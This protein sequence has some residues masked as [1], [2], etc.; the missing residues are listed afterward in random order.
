M[1]DS[2]GV[3]HSGL[4]RGRL[5]WNGEYTVCVNTKGSLTFNGKNE[6]WK[7]YYSYI[8]FQ[9]I[10][11]NIENSLPPILSAYCATGRCKNFLKKIKNG[12]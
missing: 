1:E 4:T 2:H 6:T 12:K 3:Q 10:R 7:G 9:I 5:T 11:E 8:D